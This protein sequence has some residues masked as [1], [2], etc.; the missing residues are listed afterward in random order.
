MNER[1]RRTQEQEEKTR[2]IKEMHLTIRSLVVVCVW[3]IQGK[4]KDFVNY[5]VTICV[6]E[7]VQIKCSIFKMMMKEQT[8][9]V[10][11]AMTSDLILFVVFFRFCNKIKI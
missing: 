1:Q 4:E 9:S 3:K 2:E 5:L 7:I 8:F 6:V 11:Y 10:L